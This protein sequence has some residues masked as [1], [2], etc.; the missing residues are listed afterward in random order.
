MFPVDFKE[1]FAVFSQP[2]RRLFGGVTLA[3]DEMFSVA[4]NSG[5]RMTEQT[6]ERLDAIV[7]GIGIAAS[8]LALL[9]A[10]FPNATGLTI[11]SAAVAL[12]AALFRLFISRR[13]AVFEEAEKA[14]HDGR[15]AEL[16]KLTVHLAGSERLSAFVRLGTAGEILKSKNVSSVTDHGVGHFGVTFTRAFRTTDYAVTPIGGAAQAYE[17]LDQT[18]QGLNLRIQG[19][20]PKSPMAFLFEDKGF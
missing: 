17:V 14:L 2:S 16:E 11:A 13:L 4:E 1:L 20:D 12:L 18:P 10:F 7:T 5:A 15:I 8:T 6:A 3:N 19:G 9:S